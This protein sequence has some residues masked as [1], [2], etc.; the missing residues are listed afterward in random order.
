MKLG[1]AIRPECSSDIETIGEVI[2]LAFLGMPFADGDE[3]E[4]VDALRAQK[5]LSV[6]LVA[7][8]EGTIVGQVAFSPARASGGTASWY[9]LGP[10]AVHPPYQRRGIGTKL[11]RAGLEA[12]S[13]LGASGCIL[14]GDPAYYS[15]FGFKLSPE[16]APPGE[17]S[18][19]F[20][21]KLLRGQ[22]PV[23]SIHF[24]EAFGGA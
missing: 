19:H 7:D 24:H 4:L 1:V 11:V 15:R 18:M 5:A 21:V 8:L 10:V 2:R 22:L 20:M 12:V 16:N 13:D 14:T 23:G 17:P 9:A 3:P 6:S